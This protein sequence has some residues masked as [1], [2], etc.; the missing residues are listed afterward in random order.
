MEFS[1]CCVLLELRLFQL[2]FSGE[3]FQ[4]FPH[5]FILLLHMLQVTLSSVE[6]V[7]V[8]SA[9][10]SS[11]V[12]LYYFCLLI[13]KFALL[14]FVFKLLIFHKLATANVSSPDSLY[15][16]SCPLFIIKLP[17]DFE[18]PPI[19]LNYNSCRILFVSE[20]LSFIQHFVVG[21]H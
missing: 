12:F 6:V 9:V 13:E 18:H 11:V 1:S 10:V 21:I 4:L 15:F 17:L 19:F 7:L 2:C 8:L 16:Q 3:L 5:F 14:I 20:L